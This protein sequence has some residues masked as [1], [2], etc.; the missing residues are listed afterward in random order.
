V[1]IESVAITACLLLNT[2]P[3]VVKKCEKIVKKECFEKK[4][5]RSYKDCN[6]AVS[7]QINVLMK[8]QYAKACLLQ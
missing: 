8:Q 4:V 5:M 2:S 7:P 6:E 1:I 3:S